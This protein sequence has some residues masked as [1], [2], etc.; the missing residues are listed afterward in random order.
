MTTYQEDTVG[1][2]VDWEELQVKFTPTEA[3]VV[4]IEGWAWWV[5]NAADESVWFDDVTISQV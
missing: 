1:S 3:G 5:A 4:E 2:T